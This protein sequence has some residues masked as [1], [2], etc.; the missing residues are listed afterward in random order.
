[1][2]NDGITT[3]VRGALKP[4]APCAHKAGR[5]GHELR[6]GQPLQKPRGLKSEVQG[7]CASSNETRYHAD[8]AMTTRSMC[9]SEFETV[10]CCSEFNLTDGNT[11]I[12]H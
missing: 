3:R 1:M 10:M 8:S 2:S 12:S 5:V 9:C 6:A 11:Q 7:Q 4:L